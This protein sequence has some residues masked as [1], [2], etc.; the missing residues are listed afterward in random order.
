MEKSKS[1]KAFK[2]TPS[3]L[4]AKKFINQSVINPA[5][6]SR[7]QSLNF[8]GTALKFQASTSI[9]H[10]SNTST[11]NQSLRGSI[12]LNPSQRPRHNPTH[13]TDLPNPKPQLPLTRSE[14][15]KTFA[16]FLNKFELKELQ[17]FRHVY[18]VRQSFVDYNEQHFSKEGEYFIIIGDSICYRYEILEIIDSGSFG[19]VLKCIDHKNKEKVAI[20]VL[21]NHYNSKKLGLNEFKIVEILSKA[22]NHNNIVRGKKRFL[23]RHHF[24]MVFELLGMNLYNFLQCN[25]F[26]PVSLGLAKRIAAQLLKA[27][28]HIHSLQIIHCDIKPENIVFKQNNKSSIRIIDFGTSC[29][30]NRI[31]F[32]YFQTRIYRA[33]EVVLKIGN[34]GPEIDIWS[35]GCVVC[36]L[37]LGIPLFCA[38]N[39]KELLINMCE[40]LGPPPDELLIDAKLDFDLCVLEWKGKPKLRAILENYNADVVDFIESCLVWKPEDRITASEGL[41]ANWFQ[42]SHSRSSSLEQLLSRF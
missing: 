33:P 23:F 31:I 11:A 2:E 7:M 3:S 25:K 32:T 6:I 42:T 5:C 29:T 1:L 27:L 39:E 18:F 28:Q 40:V 17:K 12:D 26:M 13:S 21:A 30:N 14:A 19:Q 34:Y 24:F 15:I 4:R 35:L 41:Q 22:S 8:S 16:R 37:L 10:I 36:E 20:K 38:E 9:S